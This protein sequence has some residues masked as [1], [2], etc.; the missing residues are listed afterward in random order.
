MSLKSSYTHYYLKCRNH[1]R[2]A[3]IHSSGRLRFQGFHDLVLPMQTRSSSSPTSANSR[4]KYPCRRCKPFYSNDMAKSGQPL[5]I[6]TLHT[7]YVVEKLI[8]LTIISDAEIILCTTF[9]LNTLKV[10]ASVFNKVHASD[11]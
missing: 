1:L 5:Y 6:N 11:P 9:L 8:H 2:T 7:V 3:L 4:I 10:V